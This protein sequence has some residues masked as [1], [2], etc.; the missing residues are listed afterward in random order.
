MS[1][2]FRVIC[3]VFVL[4][5][6]LLFSAC[7]GSG[8]EIEVPLDSSSNISSVAPS[9]Q[10]VDNQSN[11]ISSEDSD[12]ETSSEQDNPFN[13]EIQS[14]QDVIIDMGEELF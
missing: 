2:L 7:K 10:I 14:G 8:N 9:S 5:V 6:A 1:T 13:S 11:D 4:S 12:T 3:V